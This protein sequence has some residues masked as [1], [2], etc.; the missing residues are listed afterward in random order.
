MGLDGWA[1]LTATDPDERMLRV[2]LANATAAE[3]R[4]M[5]GG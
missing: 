2:A 3:L 1:L 4:R 5:H